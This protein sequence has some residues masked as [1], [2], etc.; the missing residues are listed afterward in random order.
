MFSDYAEGQ[1]VNMTSKRLIIK[2][3]RNQF[4]TNK[5][6]KTTASPWK[7]LLPGDTITIEFTFDVDR[8]YSKQPELKVYAYRNDEL[9]FETTNTAAYIAK[10]LTHYIFEEK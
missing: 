2:S 1:V 8:W 3:W 9:L 7:D 5:P 10:F 6:W 4:G